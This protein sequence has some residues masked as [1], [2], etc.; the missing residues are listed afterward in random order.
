MAEGVEGRAAQSFQHR[1]DAKN[2]GIQGPKL[3]LRDIALTSQHGQACQC[4]HARRERAS[5][6]QR[7]LVVERDVPGHHLIGLQFS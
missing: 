4:L 6:R 3:R 1:H 2:R 5:A 7:V